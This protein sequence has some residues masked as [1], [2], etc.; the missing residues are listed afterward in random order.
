[1][2]TTILTVSDVRDIVQRV[3]LD[4]LM[5]ESIT[6]LGAAFAAFDPLKVVV[7]ARDGFQYQ[8]P[9]LGLIEWMPCMRA[10]EAAHIKVVGY[11]PGNSRRHDLPT[12]LSTLS[13]YG[14]QDGHLRGVMDATFITALRTGAAS[15]VASR[16]LAM[17]NT[18]TL[19]LIGC[20]AQ[21]VTQLHAL[22]RVFDIDRVEIYD[23]DSEAM[24]SFSQ[25]LR[26]LD[27]DN[28]EVRPA[29]PQEILRRADILCT[30]TSIGIG[31]GP[32]FDYGDFKQ[33]LH[34]NAIGSD[35]PGKIELP[36][37]FVRESMVCPDFPD[38]ALK[39]GECQRLERSE[40]G[41]DIHTLVKHQDDYLSYRAR[42]TV[43]DS[44][45]WAVEDMVCMDMFM[46]YAAEFGIGMQLELE[47][48]S[49]DALNPYQF[50][51]DSQPGTVLREAGTD[52]KR[53]V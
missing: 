53:A 36:A 13:M 20:G 40:M 49:T 32:V 4:T 9:D 3:G 7:P 34:V 8:A 26:C 30:A 5:E 10:G 43:F 52:L 12:I 45:G 15:A 16:I 39:E 48:I 2:H 35:F 29:K 31:E 33:H 41:P 24:A 46:E 28:V 51:F 18:A 47:S 21:A 50:L 42:P 11:H 37:R 44:T 23:T 14:V 25:R 22:S 38:Q 27:L 6:R 1:M 19:G 17:E